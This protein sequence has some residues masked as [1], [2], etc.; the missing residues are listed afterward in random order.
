MEALD[1]LIYKISRLPGLGPKSAR[2][3]AYHLLKN[4]AEF[5][6][7]LGEAIINIKDR[8]HPCPVCGI[9][10]EHAI[11]SICNDS[12]RNREFLCIVEETQDVNVIE[13]SGVYKGLYHVLGG[14][15]SILD[16]IYPE[17]LRFKELDKRIAEGQFT[18]IIIATNPTDQ[19]DT[20]AA[21]IKK[22]LSKYPN[23]HFSRIAQGLQA[24]GDIEF[25]NHR[26]LYQSFKNRLSF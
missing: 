8:V 15:I 18:E 11:C 16:G 20:T 26:A 25:A 14:A 9:Y 7:A 1:S 10:T 2:R 17:N 13:D 12:S 23:L 6:K 22:L 21:Y 5:N 24:G 4:D 19:G 3:I